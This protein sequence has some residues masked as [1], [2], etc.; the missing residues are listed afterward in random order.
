VLTGKRSY[1]PETGRAGASACSLE[2]ASTHPTIRK[3]IS[4]MSRLGF[5]PT[6]LF[7]EK[8]VAILSMSLIHD[9]RPHSPKRIPFLERL[10]TPPPFFPAVEIPSH[11]RKRT[12]GIGKRERLLIWWFTYRLA[13]ERGVDTAAIEDAARETRLTAQQIDAVRQEHPIHWERML[14][15]RELRLAHS[16]KHGW[17]PEGV[18]PG[19]PLGRYL[20]QI[21]VKLWRRK[22]HPSRGTIRATRLRELLALC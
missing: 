14:L 10:C 22:I 21:G 6:L 13:V 20:E 8:A 15:K 9:E 11:L 12:K 17:A 4:P 1:L 2:E 7:T 5:T 3:I 16:K 18:T 19:W